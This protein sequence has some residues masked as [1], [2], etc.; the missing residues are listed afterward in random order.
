MSEFDPAHP[1]A[2]ELRAFSLGRVG[3]NDLTRIAAHLD[4]CPT[5]QGR[6]DGLC[7][8][9]PLLTQLQAADRPGGGFREDADQR[10]QAARAL[11]QERQCPPSSAGPL[12]TQGAAAQPGCPREIGE[13]DILGE[14]GRGTRP[15]CAALPA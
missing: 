10:R 12:A 2:E 8:Q 7:A 15:L 13:Y 6:V 5:C 14:V 4:D 1:S 11:R 3:E 9:D